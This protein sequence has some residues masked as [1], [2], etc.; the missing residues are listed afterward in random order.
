MCG[1]TRRYFD[2]S[3][4]L[5]LYTTSSTIFRC[6]DGCNPGKNLMSGF[7]DDTVVSHSRQNSV[8]GMVHVWINLACLEIS[9][10]D[11]KPVQ[12]ELSDRAG[13]ENNVHSIEYG[14]RNVYNHRAEY[15]SLIFIAFS[16]HHTALSLRHTLQKERNQ[17]TSSGT[18]QGL[19]ALYSP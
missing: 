17:D 12:V 9:G 3:L 13:D 5:I 18:I 6:D 2:A 15:D 14:M 1:E 8:L 16:E 4:R 19:V 11:S 10:F 7:L